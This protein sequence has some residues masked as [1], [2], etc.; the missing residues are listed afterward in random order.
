M[1]LLNLM[2]VRMI[3]AIAVLSIAPSIAYADDTSKTAK[4]EELFRLTKIDQLLRQSLTLAT[5]QVKSG[6]IQQMM[7]VKLPPDMEKEVG[8][9]QDK[10]AGI[11]SDALAW[12]KLKPAYLKVYLDAYSE[13]ELDGIIA[14]YKSPA[15]QAMVTKTP[16]L[17]AK[18]SGIVRERITDV[19][20][21]LTKLMT[22]F[23]AQIRQR[24]GDK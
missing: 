16:A 23:A 5:E 18:S 15:G 11:V 10:V 22:D 4:V 19:Q 20:P 1:I 12:D 3:T 14:F 7:G 2:R 9:M 17:M 21:Q 13:D 6:L 8:A 24:N